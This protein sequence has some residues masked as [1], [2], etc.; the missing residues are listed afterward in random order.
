MHII[1]FRSEFRMIIGLEEGVSVY[2]LMENWSLWKE[3]IIAYSHLEKAHQRKLRELLVSLESTYEI[4]DNGMS[5]D[6][7]YLVSL[8]ISL[9]CL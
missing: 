8:C 1:Q 7:L 4:T 3:R 2:S 6:L 9:L 5:N